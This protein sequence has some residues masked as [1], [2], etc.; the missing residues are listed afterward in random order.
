[1]SGNLLTIE[2]P[3]DMLAEILDEMSITPYRLARAIGKAPIQVK[4]ILDGDSRITVSMSRRIGKALG[5]SEGYWL[6]LQQDYD[7]RLS[8]RSESL[9]DIAVLYTEK[10]LLERVF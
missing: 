8:A 4:R 1:M 6:R 7:L 10:D 2:T 9:E 5:M 3:G